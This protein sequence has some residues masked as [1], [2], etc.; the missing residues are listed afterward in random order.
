MSTH[1]TS[2]VKPRRPW[3]WYVYTLFRFVIIPFMLII[4][5]VSTWGGSNQTAVWGSVFFSVLYV[6]YRVG[7]RIAPRTDRLQVYIAAVAVQFFVMAAVAAYTGSD[8][9]VVASSGITAMLASL[10]AV[11]RG[12]GVRLSRLEAPTDGT[13]AADFPGIYR[14]TCRPNGKQY[15]GQ[16]S[17]AINARWAEHRAHLHAQRHHNRWLQA[18]WDLY[19]PEQFGWEVL[20]V[21]TDPV[22]LLDRER[23]WQDL[24][25]DAAKRYNP[26]NLAPRITKASS[27]PAMKRRIRK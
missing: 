25:Y 5:V 27:R 3:G 24:G 17:Q 1:Y 15:I 2:F 13:R 14:I 7:R 26:P 23:Y 16:T 4:V 10:A 8:A 6:A 21:V 11:T 20:E 12:Y 18:D 9:D 19:R 22:W